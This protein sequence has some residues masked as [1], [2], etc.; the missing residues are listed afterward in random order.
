[1]LAT[2]GLAMLMTALPFTRLLEKFL[3]YQLHKTLGL[4]VFGMV[5]ARLVLRGQRPAP[6]ALG[7]AG[8]RPGQAVL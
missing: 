1:M 4:L 3:A 7:L 5:L 8:A 6:P 2:L